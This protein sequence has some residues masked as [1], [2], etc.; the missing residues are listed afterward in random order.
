MVTMLWNSN[1]EN[2]GN[3]PKNDIS[4]SKTPIYMKQSLIQPAMIMLCREPQ[5][6]RVKFLPFEK[7]IYSFFSSFG[8][9]TYAKV[10]KT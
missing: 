2:Y 3:S 9:I 8:I 6:P 1:R 10:I 4:K 5:K 7:F